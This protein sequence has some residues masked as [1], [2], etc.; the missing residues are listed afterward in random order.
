ML[1]LSV[2]NVLGELL[3]IPTPDLNP[4]LEPSVHYT[5]QSLDFSRLTSFQLALDSNV[6]IYGCVQYSVPMLMSM[7]YYHNRSMI[8][9]C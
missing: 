9:A 4:I 8:V 7:L 2:I 1:R 6:T 5:I 3:K